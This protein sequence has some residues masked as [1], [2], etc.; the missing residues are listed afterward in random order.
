MHAVY[1]LLVYF[2][3]RRY[4]VCS[5]IQWIDKEGCEFYFRCTSVEVVLN[6]SPTESQ[7]FSR[8]VY[9]PV[10]PSLQSWDIKTSPF[11]P[12]SITSESPFTQLLYGL[13]WSSWDFIWEEAWRY[14]TRTKSVPSR[15]LSAKSPRPF[16]IRLPRAV[17]PEKRLSRVAERYSR[18]FYSHAKLHPDVWPTWRGKESFISHGAELTIVEDMT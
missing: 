4:S 11:H 8:S 6:T 18:E 12:V 17:T 15:R 2:S 7:H 1:K 5:N 9:V 10:V 16:V 14:F 3:Q 13:F